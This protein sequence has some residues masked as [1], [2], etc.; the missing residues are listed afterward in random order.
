MAPPSSDVSLRRLSVL[1]AALTSIGPFA[2]DTYLPA[3]GLIGES[4]DASPLE[5][6]QTLSIYLLMFGVMNLWHGAISDA[7]GRRVVLL[8]GL[9]LFG[10][11]CA[12]A[13]AS[14]TVGQLWGWRAVQGIAGG[15]GMAVGRA[16]IRDVAKGSD[17]QRILAQTMMLFALAPAVAPIIGGWIAIVFGWRAIFVFLT[18][19]SAAIFV[20]TW[21]QLPETL[22]AERRQSLHPGELMRAYA[23]F[24]SSADFWRLSGALACNFVGFFLFILASPV[25]MTVHLGLGPTGFAWLFLPAMAGTMVGGFLASRFAGR[26]SLEWAIRTGYLIMACAATANVALN[27]AGPSSLPWAILPIFLYTTGM[28][29][30]QSSLQVRLLDLAPERMGMVSSCQAFIQSLGNALAAA[31]LA[32]LLWDSMLHLA[33]GMAVLLAIGGL[34]YLWQLRHG[35]RVS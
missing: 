22:P 33:L 21:Y 9:A 14:S 16:V 34:L 3:F 35:L 12:G 19:L 10:L 5:V 20:S 25:L 23:R 27:L 32:P 18:L 1:V 4:L 24:F 26:R 13:A 8:A 31:V 15:V 29:F 7:L 17:A 30:A 6:Q 28:G 11:G 2:I